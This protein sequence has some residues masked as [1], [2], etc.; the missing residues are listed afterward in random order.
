MIVQYQHLSEQA[1]VFRSL[2][3]LSVPEFDTLYTDMQGYYVQAE[4]E[5]LE[6]PTRQR[7]IGAGH[8]FSLNARDQI[9]LT[10]VW[11]RVYP[12]YEV[13]GYLF[14]VSDTTTGRVMQR[15][16]PMLE[17]MGRD[18][19][20]LPQPSRKRRRQLDELL[21]DVPEL[22][23]IIDSFEQAVQR[24]TEHTAAKALFSGKK[25]RHTL[26]SQMAINED[27]G[28]IVDISESVAGPTAD[29]TLLRRSKL[30][31]RLPPSVRGLGDLGYVGIE[32]EGCGSA[33]GGVFS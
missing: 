27:T 26:K 22:A 13:L 28:Y 21:R 17:K 25:K 7:D 16:L 8:P 5:R 20:R 3:G 2:S 11:L 31:K 24:P 30:M 14:G 18:G 32:R 12:T 29:M 23:V 1:S 10:V 33:P 9:L 6:R 4:W 19:M 15:V